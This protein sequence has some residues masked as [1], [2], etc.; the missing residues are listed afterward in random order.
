MEMA[1]HKVK[2]N[3]VPNGN[4]PPHDAD[5]SPD[6]NP[7]KV[8]PGQTIRFQLGIGPPNGKIQI[9]FTDTERHFFSTPNPHFATDGK[10]HDGDGDVHIVS[11]L[12]G[13]THYQCDLL[14]DGVVKASSP[15]GGEIVPDTGM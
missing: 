1:D 11:A 5:F 7:I 9:T 15:G 3:Y 12:T 14:V 2:L 6:T 10:F 13:P 8:R 4:P